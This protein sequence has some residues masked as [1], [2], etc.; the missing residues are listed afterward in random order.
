MTPIPK[1]SIFAS[2][3]R[4]Q[5]WM[6]LY[7]SL[8]DNKIDYEIVFVGPNKPDYQL[9]DNFRFIQSFVKPAQ[10]FEIA[11]RNCTA[12][13]VMAIADDC[14]FKT[15]KSLDHLYEIYKSYNNE[16]I[17]VSCR[18]I[19]DGIVQPEDEHHFISSD[20]TFFVMPL[21]GLMSRKLFT[22]IGGIDKNFIAV[23][24]DLDVAMRVY[25]LGGDVIMSDV[26]VHELKARSAGSLLCNEFW[27]HDRGLLE[28]LWKKNSK[29][30]VN[31]TRPVESFLD[32]KLLEESQGPRGR[33]HGS[34]PVI[35]EF[36]LDF[37][38]LFKNKFYNIP[39]F[40]KL[41]QNTRSF[42]QKILGYFC[43]EHNV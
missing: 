37:Y 23:M 28:T 13:L 30:I 9:P 34:S 6:F 42:L 22:N 20:M 1:I 36:F 38:L 8:R 5:N 3:H 29:I 15:P 18:Y 39:N 21:C 16:K 19:L 12:E 17:I 27:A 25:A 10:C 41:Y 26:Y 33:W 11:F 40:R 14:V 7:D 31:R 4:P 24:W 2:A 32:I 35:L 43:Q